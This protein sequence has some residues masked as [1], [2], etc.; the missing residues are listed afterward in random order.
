LTES[1]AVALAR[2]WLD[3]GAA[4]PSGPTDTRALAWALKDEGYAAFGREPARSA[5]AAQMLRALADATVGDMAGE[6][7]SLAQWAQAI[8]CLTRGE[9]AQALEA[10]D[11][12]ASGLRA[13]GLPDPAA[14]T[15]VPK[16]MA[17]SMLGHHDEAIA[18][19]EAAQRELADLGNLGAAAR[20]SQNLGS[21]QFRRDAY[22]EAASHFRTAA[23][24]F[25]RLSDHERSVNADIGLADS[26][27]SMGDFDEARRI[28]ARARTLAQSHALEA[29]GAMIDESE[30]L[31]DLARG[32]Y[33]EALA[34]FESARRRYAA[35]A[36][37]QYLAIAEK[38]LADTY[39]ELRLLP[40]ALSLF[41]AAVARFASLSLPDEQAWAL[42]QRG[43][44]QA[45]LGLLEADLSFARAAA[46]FE[47]QGSAIGAAS[48]ELAR[49]EIALERGEAHSAGAG[50]LRAAAG[51]EL[52]AQADGHTRSEVIHALAVLEAGDAHRAAADFATTLVRARERSQVQVQVRC[53]TGLGRCALAQGDAAAA[54]AH[55]E[56]A[57]ALFEEQRAALP[58]D[59]IRTAFLTDQLRPYEECLRLALADG[60]GRD[61]LVQLERFR[62][63]SLD[64]RVAEG[65]SA[66]D[67]PQ[68]ARLR[69]RLNWLYR[70]VQRL[71][72]E[73]G[74]PQ[75]FI[76]EMQRSEQA[77]LE[78]A[79]R[80]RLA[81]PATNAP[82]VA[83]LDPASLAR[84]L[85][86]GEALVEYGS[87]DGRIFACVVTRAGVQL[88]P[89]LADAVQ[90][91]DAIDAL[92]F[93]L[94]ALRH[95]EAPVRQHLDVL[96][97]RA[98][99]RLARLHELVW[100]PLASALA[101]CVRVLVVPQAALGMVPFSALV[102]AV[103]RAPA[104]EIALVPSA[105]AA[106][107]GL[108]QRPRPPRQVVALGESSRLAHTAD[109]ARHV[110]GLFTG[111]C[112]FV[113]AEA[114]VA[115]LRTHAGG[116]DVLH[117]A[118]HAQFRQDN[119][120]FSMLH[121][122]EGAL[123]AEEA[124]TLALEGATVVLSACETGLAEH[125]R[126]DEMVGLVRSF[127]VAGAARVVASQWP[128]DDAV[129]K[130]F[131]T[132]FYASL[133]RGDGTAAA[134]ASA[135]SVTRAV[136]PHPVFWAAFTLWGGW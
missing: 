21:L 22:A 74:H 42:A 31:L 115:T 64:E 87:L 86:P 121:L 48:I 124:E 23:Q 90:V 136:R 8:A 43:R 11:A 69:E 109:E 133:A 112:A 104:V 5:L 10:L 80:R 97:A 94:E 41:D 81:A 1:G 39:L 47:A 17:L 96:A 72:D 4:L 62:A 18:C 58:G 32:R 29:P 56:S 68:A 50:A 106:L 120:R 95:G 25:S 71:E 27:T 52:A 15:Q 116:A 98:Q 2:Q 129:T 35:L 14:Q 117:L 54:R 40:E 103:G 26:L 131:M 65:G 105:R 30:A 59:E 60:D 101:G 38:Q 12:A 132:A 99:A 93:Q 118:C 89:A 73:A 76:E 45:L 75:A 88:V 102:Q 24:M 82:V 127:L 37:P 55:F 79:R 125:G 61:V 9:M 107:R 19:A 128:V 3:G 7:E 84:A 13:A 36:V 126:G 67:D 91:G 6:I 113:G 110:A 122:H 49:A 57:I 70:R 78:G 77:L 53:L 85:Q 16:I 51:F 123:S 20:V 111:G 63:R 108:R 92:R 135:Q 134:L 28:Y 130:T 44:T 83:G 33:R 119:P 46:L 34:G 100:A 114:T 66:D